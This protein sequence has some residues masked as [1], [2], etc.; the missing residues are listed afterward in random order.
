MAVYCSLELR[1]LSI[2]LQE[3]VLNYSGILEKIMTASCA[4]ARI[5]TS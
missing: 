1:V 5:V 3:K 4:V 2:L